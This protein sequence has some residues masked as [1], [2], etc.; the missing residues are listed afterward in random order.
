MGVGEDPG[1]ILQKALELPSELELEVFGWHVELGGRVPEWLGVSRLEKLTCRLL[2][3]ASEDNVALWRK[4]VEGKEAREL[5]RDIFVTA[6]EDGTAISKT[7]VLLEREQ[8]GE[9]R[10]IGVEVLQACLEGVGL[11][12]LLQLE[13]EGQTIEHLLCFGPLHVCLL[14]LCCLLDFGRAYWLVG[15]ALVHFLH[16]AVLDL[17]WAHKLDWI[18]LKAEG[19]VWSNILVVRHDWCDSLQL[20]ESNFNRA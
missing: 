19:L 8:N 5:V 13:R 15:C 12:N 11:K 10:L 1:V 14:Q 6:W 18:L 7:C 16:L 9:P 3:E 17:K 2:Q 20:F 4:L